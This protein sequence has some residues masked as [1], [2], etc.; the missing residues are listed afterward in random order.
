[1]D[2][3]ATG[4]PVSGPR[5]RDRRAEIARNAGEL[6]SARGFHAV[7]M[8]DIA[9]A[10]GITARA[11][12]RHYRNKQALLAHVVREDQQRLSDTFGALLEL[13][14]DDRT[15]DTSLVTMTNAALDSRRLSLLWQREAR[16]L[17]GEDYR[18]VRQ[19]ARSMTRQ[20]GELTI[21]SN[22]PD[23]DGPVADIRSWVV[24][25]IITGTGLYDS[26][27]SRQ[28][29]CADLVAASKRVTIAP[30]TSAE[31][32]DLLDEGPGRNLISRREQ[33]INSAASAFRD[34]GFGG[35]SID[36]IG[37]QLGI[38][39][40]A[41]YRYFDN[42]AEILVVLVS[43]FHEW[44]V[45]EMTRALRTAASDESVI[46]Q[47]VQ[48]YVR[49]ALEATD[50]LAVALTERLYLPAAVRDRFDR[51]QADYIAEWQ[52]WMSVAHPELSDA[53]A[54][55]LV[56][57]AKTIIDDCVRIPHFRQYQ[58]FPAELEQAVLATLDLPTTSQTV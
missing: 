57:A 53:R 33:L 15:L 12:Y 51:I 5:S 48:G 40:P 28:R 16:H 22:R 58:V 26:P 38:V 11:L 52:R 17:D 55:T 27:L 50:L 45:L 44:L 2:A 14:T 49:I 8:E 19:H 54:T 20:V 43:R 21:G 7:R 4:T 35:V 32:V 46:V 34:K 23:L 3:A 56:H 36:D 42:K 13:P 1:M 18:L 10:S 39:G 24:V 25:S 9:E 6:F 30:T 41:L 31:D 29:L 37:G 47:L